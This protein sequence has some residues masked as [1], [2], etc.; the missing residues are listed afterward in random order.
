MVF[1]S[2]VVPAF[3]IRLPIFSGASIDKQV[4]EPYS[5]LIPAVF[6]KV[7]VQ[8]K[9]ATVNKPVILLLIIMKI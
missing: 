6:G 5:S 8:L 2:R 7:V 9:L 3:I 1:S 4:L